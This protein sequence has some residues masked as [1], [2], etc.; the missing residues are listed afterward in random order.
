MKVRALKDYSRFKKGQEEI[1]SN[2]SGEH[3]IKKGVVEL[4]DYVDTDDKRGVGKK[5]MN[6]K[7]RLLRKYNIEPKANYTLSYLI[8]ILEKIE[9][10]KN[11]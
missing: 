10:E 9:N 11:G 6:K 2:S 7:L 8:K 1:I 3:F 5:E 4:I